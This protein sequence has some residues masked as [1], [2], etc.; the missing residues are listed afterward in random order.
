MTWKY[1][2]ALDMDGPIMCID[3]GDFLKLG[4]S[5]TVILTSKGIYVFN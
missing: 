2:E 1:E 3:S 4:I 5:F